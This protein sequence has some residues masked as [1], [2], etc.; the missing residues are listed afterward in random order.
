MPSSSPQL[1]DLPVLGIF[2]P[3]AS[4]QSAVAEA[5]AARIPA[6]LVAADSAQLYRGLPLLT[7]QSPATLVGVWELGHEATVAEY[8]ELAHEAIDAAVAAGRTAVVVGGTGLYFRALVRG[9]F[10]G[11]ARP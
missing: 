3:T 4:G 11:P 10:P 8:Q 6:E 2:G 9:L 1:P 5:V 7:N